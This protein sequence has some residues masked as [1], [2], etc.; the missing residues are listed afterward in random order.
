[1]GFHRNLKN[2]QKV[3][4]RV[5]TVKKQRDREGVRTE[6]GSPREGRRGG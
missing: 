4:K 2:F 6:G 3:E 1:M 5:E